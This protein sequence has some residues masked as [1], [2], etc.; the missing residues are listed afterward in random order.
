MLALNHPHIVTFFGFTAKPI[1]DLPGKHS[2]YLVSKYCEGESMKKLLEWAAN[3]KYLGLPTMRHMV[4]WA[5]QICDT[6][7]FLHDHRA[8]HLDLKPEN[9]LLDAEWGKKS[10]AERIEVGRK[11][12]NAVPSSSNQERSEQAYFAISRL[13][14]E[15]SSKLTQTQVKLCDLGTAQIVKKDLYM[16]NRLVGTP[17]FMPPEM[18]KAAGGGG[19]PVPFFEDDDSWSNMFEEKEDAKDDVHGEDRNDDGL[20]RHPSMYTRESREIIDLEDGKEIVFRTPLPL[21]R[22]KEKELSRY[23]YAAVGREAA[24]AASAPVGAAPAPK[25][26]EKGGSPVTP[27]RPKTKLP[28]SAFKTPKRKIPAHV[29]R[30]LLVSIVNCSALTTENKF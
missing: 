7:Q 16:T 27:I 22:E 6:M 18:L 23:R 1:D 25:I 29:G 30:R 8:V 19:S 17:A 15:I 12:A 3:N 24:R 10:L 5:I 28:A 26:V 13:K 21:S 9:V 4:V 14:A 11:Y 2:L 20:T